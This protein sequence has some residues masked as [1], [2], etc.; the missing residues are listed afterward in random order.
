MFDSRLRIAGQVPR[1]GHDG[2]VAAGGP[3]IRN[4]PA[5]HAI[6][7][8]T[9]I[10]YQTNHERDP[11]ASRGCR[12][13]IC[14]IRLLGRRPECRR[15]RR[16]GRSGHGD[17]RRGKRRRRGRQR[18]G[19]GWDHDWL[20]AGRNRWD[21]R[22]HRRPGFGPVRSALPRGRPARLR[23]RR[24]GVRR[25]EDRRLSGG[26]TKRV[27]PEGRRWSGLRRRRFRPG[28]VPESGIRF[29]RPRVLD[30]VHAR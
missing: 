29:G 23:R 8:G 19:Y 27:L 2:N 16:C 7:G 1:T 28:D 14:S 15:N 22:R 20:R 26:R 4:G 6:I 11:L 24:P 18:R 3:A 30:V 5:N 21:Q 10:A 9:R 13:R 12:G 25:R 17:G